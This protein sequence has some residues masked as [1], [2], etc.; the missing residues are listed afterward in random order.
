MS[1]HICHC[2][3]FK[4]KKK[5]NTEI[6]DRGGTTVWMWSH[7]LTSEDLEIKRDCQHVSSHPRSVD[8]CRLKG[9]NVVNSDE[10]RTKI[11][12]VERAAQEETG[13]RAGAAAARSVKADVVARERGRESMHSS[14]LCGLLWE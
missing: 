2:A 7:K 6:G 10:N 4:N 1:V 5:H 12:F 11:F 3:I 9:A 14:F 8:G 13:N